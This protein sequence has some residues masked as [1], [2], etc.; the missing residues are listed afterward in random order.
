MPLLVESNLRWDA[1]TQEEVIGREMES[2]FAQ[3]LS[4]MGRP[5]VD[6]VL[7]TPWKQADERIIRAAKAS[8]ESLRAEGVVRWIGQ[9]QE[10][11]FHTVDRFFDFVAT[12]DS[13]IAK[14]LADQATPTLFCCEIG[15]DD[16]AGKTWS[17]ARQFC[18]HRPEDAQAV[19]SW[20][21]A[22]SVDAT[23]C[24]SHA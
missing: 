11:T 2:E 4:C 9:W 22:Q 16:F 14:A 15:S 18:L 12:H 20:A 8:L 13:K 7:L 1:Y 6:A 10:E 24:T 17:I 23:E 5:E 21:K 19:V 3:W